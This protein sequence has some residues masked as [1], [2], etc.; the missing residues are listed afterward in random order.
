MDFAYVMGSTPHL[1]PVLRKARR[2]GYLEPDDLLRLAGIRGCLHY[3][4]PEML[5]E[6]IQDCGQTHFSNEELVVALVSGSMEGD[7][8]HVRVAAQLLGA[9]GVDTAKVARLAKMERCVPIIRYIAESGQ[10]ED[11]E[12]K[13]FWKSLLALLPETPPIPEG[14]M[15]HP[16]RFMS[17]P[18][19]SPPSRPPRRASWL[20]AHA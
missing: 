15:P 10:R 4:S 13:A 18:G 5:S 16:S 1:S 7:A 19:W 9:Q 6:A 8:R 2:L 17:Q 11:A 12:R 14:R 20:R 3:S